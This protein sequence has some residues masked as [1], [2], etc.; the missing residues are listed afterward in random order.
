MAARAVRFH[1]S[2]GTFHVEPMLTFAKANG[3]DLNG[4]K[5]IL[6]LWVQKGWIVPRNGGGYDVKNRRPRKDPWTLQ[7]LRAE[8][9]PVPGFIPVKTVRGCHS[10]RDVLVPLDQALADP[11]QLPPELIGEF[12]DFM[13]VGR[14]GFPVPPAKIVSSGTPDG[15]GVKGQHPHRVIMDEPFDG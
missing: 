3:T 4:A 6:E 9:F 1:H 7:Q 8:G 11:T 15:K 13:Q 12:T 14:K 5:R 2:N 10:T